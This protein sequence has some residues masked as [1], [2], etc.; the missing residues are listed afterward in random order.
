VRAPSV[1]ERF[2]RVSH[3]PDEALDLEAL[4]CEI[5]RMGTPDLRA[6]AVRERLDALAGQARGEIEPDAPPDR[7][8]RA[9]AGAMHGSLGFTGRGCDWSS[10]SSSYIDATLERRTGLPIALA[11][12]WMGVGRR[13]GL[14]IAGVGWPGRFL[15]SLD[16]PGARLFADPYEDGRL[17]RAED[18]L[19]EAGPQGR[20]LLKP[21]AARAIA[22]RMLTNLKHLWIDA[23]EW[24]PALGAIDRLLL[25][26]G[27][28]APQLR[29][30][31]LVAI[32]LDRRTEARRDLQRY[33]HLQPDAH[34]ADTV[35][36]IL[37]RTSEPS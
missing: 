10:P 32:R 34:D 27:E 9:F 24:E 17:R 8:A 21:L 18:L 23:G 4:A 11:V 26:Q 37:A 36:S 6:E 12:V 29:D 31:A 5:A 22:A 28:V 13:L 30:R 14:P 33:L 2:V 3:V 35:R 16:F 20:S 1:M 15:V 19:E 25:L 7:L